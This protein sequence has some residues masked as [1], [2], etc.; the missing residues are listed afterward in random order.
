[1][2][3]DP[4]KIWTVFVAPPSEASLCS[5]WNDL[6]TGRTLLA[7]ATDAAR[8]KIIAD[9]VQRAAKAAGLTRVVHLTPEHDGALAA[10]GV[11]PVRMQDFPVVY[12][13]TPDPFDSLDLNDLIDH[14]GKPH[15]P[16]SE[17]S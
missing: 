13:A 9:A 7:R 17:R 16:T 14:I 1:M 10:E 4:P 3:P 2:N 5:E 6:K 12:E 11:R 15:P 8:A